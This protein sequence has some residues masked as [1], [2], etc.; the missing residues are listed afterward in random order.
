MN[1][2][3]VCVAFI[4]RKESIDFVLCPWDQQKFEGLTRREGKGAYRDGGAG[5]RGGEKGK[6]G[7]TST[8]APAVFRFSPSP[9][10]SLRPPCLPR[11]FSQ[12]SSQL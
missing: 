7:R 8:R 12:M 4:Y 2:N 1:S 9:P 3:G 11:N 5:R 10:P 6:V